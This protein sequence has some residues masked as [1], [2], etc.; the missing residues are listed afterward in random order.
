MSL[1]SASAAGS[2]RHRHALDRK[3]IFALQD[4]QRADELGV[5]G[6]MVK[7]GAGPQHSDVVGLLHSYREAVLFPD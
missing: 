6:Y 7:S 2:Y 3:A 5:A 4:K 1:L